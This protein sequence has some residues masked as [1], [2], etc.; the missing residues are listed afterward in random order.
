MNTTTTAQNF[1]D[2]PGLGEVVKAFLMV[3][4][5]LVV[6]VAIVRVIKHVSAGQIG[7][8]FKTV[9]G[10]LCL[11]AFMLFPGQLI[12]PAISAFSGVVSSVISTVSS[13]GS[14]NTTGTPGTTPVTTPT[15]LPTTTS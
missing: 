7:A 5:L 14:N 10:S 2:T 9:I 1:F 11:A 4:G 8:A 3:L 13:F 15:A 6:V 12:Y